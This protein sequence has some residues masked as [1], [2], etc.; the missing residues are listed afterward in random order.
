LGCRRFNGV[1]GSISSSSFEG[2][3]CMVEQAV[4]KAEE[5]YI[6]P[7]PEDIVSES[8]AISFIEK[9][10]THPAAWVY[11]VTTILSRP[12]P[13]QYIQDREGPQHLKLF[14]V[15]GAYAIATRAA[16]TRIGIFSDF[17]VTD[18]TQEG[19]ESASA[20]GKLT[21]KFFYKD[22][23]LTTSSSQVGDCPKRTGMAWG[24]VKKGAV[25]D[26]LKKCLSEF[27]WASDVYAMA[28]EKA[29]APPS[30]EEVKAKNIEYVIQAAKDKGVSPEELDVYSKSK[31][32]KDVNELDQVTLVALRRKIQSKGGL[33][34]EV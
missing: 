13:K 26:L 22:Q 7:R 2:T 3:R 10:Q 25:T 19:T 9:L 11:V 34:D 1:S 32:D 24:D 8:E 20:L 28:P 15:D 4:L 21:L 29:L 18:V 16:L 31:W 14:Y 23:I 30:E 27:G 17:E 6:V 33:K 5:Q 12:T